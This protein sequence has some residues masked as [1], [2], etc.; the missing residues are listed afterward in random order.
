MTVQELLDS[1]HII[2]IWLAA[3]YFYRVGDPIITDKTYEEYTKI[4][5][6][7]PNTKVVLAEYFCRTYDEDPIPY[8]LLEELGEKPVI[9]KI[10]DIDKYRERQKYF[11]ILNE[12]KSLSCRAIISYE[13]A[14]E[15]FNLYRKLE[16]DLMVSL[17]MD[18]INTKSIYDNGDLKLS[19]SRG[20]SSESFDFTDQT[21][22]VL[23]NKINIVKNDFKVTGESFVTYEGVT[24]LRDNVNKDKYKTCKS[25]AISLLRVRHD[26]EYYKY[27][28]TVIFNAEG[29]SETLESTFNILK[30]NGFEVVPHKLIKWQE[31]P[32][33]L[34]AFKHWA[35]S[36]IFDYMW[37]FGEITPSDGIVVEVN[38]LT[39]VGETKDQYSNR[40]IA[41]KFEQWSFSTYTGIVKNIIWRQNR[42]HASVRVEIEPIETVDGCTAQYINVFNPYILISNKIKIG[43]IIH[44]ERNSDAVNILIQNS[45]LKDG[46]VN[47]ILAEI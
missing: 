1:G 28:K 10:S 26:L 43:S 31:I 25:S 21:K 9:N 4:L 27:L 20:R 24:K 13:D 18:G 3:R 30:E 2:K 44:F 8:K 42:V 5:K 41:L 33:T 39:Y 40:Q 6:E 34:E 36:E 7:H 38:D 37:N 15:F 22:L 19:L 14:W 11:D 47:G 23:P 45:R 29:L 46:K 32:D 35:K 12:D 17:K 16:K